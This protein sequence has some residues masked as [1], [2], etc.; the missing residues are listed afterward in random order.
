[1]AQ[2]AS[3]VCADLIAPGFIDPHNH[4]TFNTLP[5]WQH[6]ERLFSNRNEWR[7]LISRELYGARP[8]GSDPVAARYSELRLLMAGTTAVHKAANVTAS[9][10]HVRICDRK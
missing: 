10:D 8:S 3:V 7:P 9:H 4:M 6:G 2:E 1:M 5:P